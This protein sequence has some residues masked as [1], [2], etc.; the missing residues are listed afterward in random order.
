MRNPELFDT[1]ATVVG[2][3]IFCGAVGKSAQFP[4]H[5]WLPDAMEGPTPVSALIHAATMVAAGVYMLCRV[6]FISDVF[7]RTRL[8]RHCLDWRHHRAAGGPDRRAAGRHQTHPGLF[9]AF[10]IGLHGDGGRVRRA[11]G[12]DVS[13]D[14]ARVF[15][16]AFVFGRRRG[17]PCHEPRAEH[18]ENGPVADKIPLTYWTFLAGT[19]ALCGL[20]PLS[21]FYSKDA[22]LA[23]A[24][25]H[26][27]DA[28]CRRRAGGFSDHFLHVPALLR[29]LPRQ[30]KS[31]LGGTP[32]QVAP[33]MPIRWS[34]WRWPP[35]WAAFWASA[36]HH[37]AIFARCGGKFRFSLRLSR[38][39]RRPGGHG[40]DWPPSPSAWARRMLLFWRGLR[41]VAWQNTG[42][43]QRPA[44]QILL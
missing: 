5:V 17:H 23:A 26:S 33:D 35:S 27:Q 2:L 15:Q 6:F 9:D 24:W 20:W 43:Q 28:L 38:S 37:S 4:L 19:L 32:A 41:P 44:P 16:G 10:A 8:H 31:D 12:G 18:L 1:T 39:K 11:A 29:R 21:G 7:S 13:F 25:E 3:L 14:H 34:F 22:I 36:V 40:W 30:A 42:H